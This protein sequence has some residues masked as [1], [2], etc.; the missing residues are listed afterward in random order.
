MN[1]FT[2]CDVLLCAVWRQEV[3][4]TYDAIYSVDPNAFIIVG[5]A[6]EITGEGFK[7]SAPKIKKSK[8]EG[9]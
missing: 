3:Y 2:E 4:K 1:G 6:G 8:N 7:K 5:D 9:K